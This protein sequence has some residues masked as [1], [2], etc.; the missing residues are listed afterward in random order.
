MG[1]PPLGCMG[2]MQEFGERRKLC[3]ALE[4][5]KDEHLSLAEQMNE[6]V[7]LANN[8]KSTAEPTK[9]KKGLTEL[10]ELASSFRAELEK[11]SRREEEDLYPLMA[12]YIERDMGPIAAMEEEHDL[13]HESLMSFMRIVEKEKSAPV[14]IAAVH[15]QLLMAVEILMEHFFKEE[16][17]LF[18]MAEYVL[19]DAEKEQL[20]ALFQD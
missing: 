10:H 8:L 14:E 7:N 16:N 12:N 9:R 17:V 19:S 15:T 11:H 5:L 1:P 13:I 20:Q 4:K 18:P 2:M 3:P 6:L